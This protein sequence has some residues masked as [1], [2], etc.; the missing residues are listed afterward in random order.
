MKDDV[1]DILDILDPLRNTFWTSMVVQWVTI[2]LSM[3]GTQVRSLVQEYSI[4]CGANKPMKHHNDGAHK[5][6][7]EAH[8]PMAC[9][10]QQEEPLQ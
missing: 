10:L 2:C 3:K 6:H 5:L 4:C 8:A 7:L 9:A 1:S